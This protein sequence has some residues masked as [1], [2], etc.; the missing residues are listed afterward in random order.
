MKSSKNL[1]NNRGYFDEDDLNDYL[2]K[3]NYG[4]LDLENFKEIIINSN[5]AIE[6]SIAI[7]LL[8][9]NYDISDLKVCSILIEQLTIEKALY[10]K[11]EIQNALSRGNAQVANLLI[12]YLGLIGNNQYNSLDD[13][14]VSRKKS[15]P[16]PRDIVARILS[17]MDSSIFSVLINSVLKVSLSQLS[18]LIDA[19]GFMVFYNDELATE[20][21]LIDI[22]KLLDIF[23]DNK[24]IIWKITTCLSSFNLKK[25]KDFLIYIKNNYDNEI[26]Q[27]EVER[28]LKFIS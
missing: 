14:I 13:A 8:A 4:S 28:S 22:I 11:L 27:K 16:L 15:Y 25:S 21:Y 10:T 26:I 12:D 20:E 7:H 3:K 6:R 5:L 1:L 9:E 17:K 2:I 24:I 23:H 18:E 19:I